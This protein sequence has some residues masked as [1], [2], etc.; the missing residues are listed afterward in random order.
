VRCLC[1]PHER[2]LFGE[3]KRGVQPR[4]FCIL[5]QGVWGLSACGASL[6]PFFLILSGC[7]GDAQ[8]HARDR[9]FIA[10]TEMAMRC[11]G[12]G[13]EEVEVKCDCM[14][15]SCECVIGFWFLVFGLLCRHT[16]SNSITTEMH[17][18]GAQ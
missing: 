15:G 16:A 6:Y 17:K 13:G 14:Q 9:L 2:T 5:C 12:V 1:T 3:G 18:S 10:K 7:W 11:R 4:L 8:R